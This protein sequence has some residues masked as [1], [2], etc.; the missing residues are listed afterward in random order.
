MFDIVIPVGPNDIDQINRQI[1][2]TKKNI[3]DYRNI[4]IVS[5][6]SKLVLDGCIIISESIFPFSINDV[7]TYH[8]KHSR[9]GWYLQQLIKLYAG[10]V[11]PG[12]LDTYLVVDSDTYFL[13]PTTF[14]EDGCCLYNPGTEY[15]TPYFEHMKQLHNSFERVDRNMSGISHHMIFETKYI[16]EMFNLVESEHKKLFW[17]IFLEKVVD[18]YESGASE[19]EIYFNYMLKYNSDK[20]KVRR[21][22]WRNVSNIDQKF[23]LDYVSWHWYRRV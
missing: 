14:V 8:G 19:Y 1:E 12:I 7:A 2:Y 10:F 13:K 22:N 21:L 23:D 20:I 15:H 3:I 5:Y 6:D 16:R 11:I 4:Y 18:I 9:N 17:I